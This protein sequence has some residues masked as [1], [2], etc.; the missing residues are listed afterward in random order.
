MPGIHSSMSRHMFTL[1]GNVLTSGGAK[2]LAKGQFAIVKS[3]SATANGAEVVS[4]FAG[5]PKSTVFE[6]RLGKHKIPK[7]R[8]AQNSIAYKSETFKLSDVVGVKANFPKNVEQTFDEILIGYDGV[9]ADTA[10]VLEEG[11]TTVL[12]INL[13]GEHVGFITGTCSYSFKM[14]F[15]REAG[16][17]N[18]EAVLRLVDRIKEQVFPQGVPVTETID[19]TPIDSSRTS[20]TGASWVFSN[21]TLDDNGESNDLAEVQAQ[22]PEYNVVRSSR[23]GRKSVYTILHP[24]T[25]SLDAFSSVVPKYLKDCEDC[26]AGYD[27]ISQDGVVYSVKIEDDGTD[28]T[29]VVDDLPGFVAASVVKKGNE[30]GIGTYTVVVD[31]ELTSA[32]ITAF[33]STAGIKSTAVISKLGTIREVCY[34]DTE[35]TTAWTVGNTCKASADVYNIQLKDDDCDGSVLA[36]LQATYPNLAISEGA[37]TGAASQEVTLTGTGGTAN[38]TIGGVDYLATF[39]TDLTTTAANF[40][41]AHA[42]D[43]LAATGVTVTSDAAVITLSGEANGFPG[44]VVVTNVATNLAGTAAAVSYTSAASTGGCQR[45]YTTTV[46]TDVLCEE[47]DEIFLGNFTSE[48][49]KSFNFSEWVLVKPAAD[50]N[51]LMGIKLK[52]KP[53]IMVPTE[54]TRDQIPFYE[55]STRIEA[56]GGYIQETTFSFEPNFSDF[57]NLKRVSRAQDRDHLGAELMSIEDASR[58]YFDG[59][60]RH[61]DNL[62][63]KAVLGEESV[64]DFQ[65]QY[66]SFEVE[67]QDSKRSQ[68]VGRSSDMGTSYIL[69][70]EFGKHEALED[71]LNSLAVAAGFD[72]VQISAE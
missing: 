48:A 38:I 6:M 56:A 7:T 69:W 44:D 71:Y 49:P 55:T 9:N 17:T 43:I 23:E 63:A 16:E 66:V 40:V 5:L 2:N 39:A 18:Q 64:L 29:A 53:F 27:A 57:F 31:N 47:C 1:N 32:E 60:V 41:T 35:T 50:G 51:A 25:A 24:A 34:D 10:L 70:A 46:V 42:A 4:S 72:A 68:G 45:V 21:L 26:G 11:Q 59:E 13:S 36:E 30:G 52:G 3:A 22:Y 65:G 61:K 15:G 20:L 28:Q 37:A 54:E 12:D 67:I 19:I 14:H 58:Y 33:A 8:T 62:F